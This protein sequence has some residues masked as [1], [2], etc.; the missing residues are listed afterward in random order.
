MNWIYETGR[1]YSVNENNE[2]V[3]EA[4]CVPAGNGTV[5]I[6]RTYVNP[7]YRGSGIAGQLM[8]AVAEHL[9][10]VGLRAVA[11]CP[12]ANAWLKRHRDTY[13]DIIAADL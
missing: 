12:Y 10:K 4:I 8:E 1:I 5:D 7:D 11:T 3:A 2:L 9:R 6:K 13:P